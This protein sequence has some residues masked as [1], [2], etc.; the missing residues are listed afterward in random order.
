MGNRRQSRSDGSAST[1]E[2]A[3]DDSNIVLSD[4]THRLLEQESVVQAFLR[5]RLSDDAVTEDLL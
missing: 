3:G 2:K 5:K 1:T 4:L